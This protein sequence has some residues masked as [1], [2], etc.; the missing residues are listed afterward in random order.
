MRIS[1][2]K[3]SDGELVRTVEQVKVY[4]RVSA[5]HKLRIVK[6]WKTRGAI[7][8]TTGDGVNDAPAVKAADIGVA[9]GMTGTDVTKEAA[10]MVVTD[11][12]FASIAA[13]VEEGR[14]VSD[15]IRKTVHFLLS[16]NVSEVLVMLCATLFGLPLPQ[17]PIHILWMN[18]V[19]DGF[20]ALALLW[21]PTRPI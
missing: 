20:P 14:G 3:L 2:Q 21:T 8:A 10:D 9:M 19:T 16:C 5:E 7:V 1:P 11:D 13:A 4:A 15:N 17:L 18:L 12:N 6:A